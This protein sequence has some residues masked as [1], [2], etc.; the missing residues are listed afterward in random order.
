MSQIC[1]FQRQRLIKRKEK[2]LIDPSVTIFDNYVTCRRR[3]L[4][5]EEREGGGVCFPPLPP[6]MF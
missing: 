5:I 2:V 3:D 6:P 1:Y 4:L